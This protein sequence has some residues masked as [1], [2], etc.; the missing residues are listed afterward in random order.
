MIRALR[1]ARLLVVADGPRNDR[2]GEQDFVAKCRQ[3]VVPDWKCDFE[4]CYSETNLGCRDRIV[5][6]LNW[7]FARVEEAIILEDDCI[8]SVPFFSFAESMLAVYRDVPQVMS[9]SGTRVFPTTIEHGTSCLSKYSNCWGWATWRRAWQH[10]LTRLPAHFAETLKVTH[11]L[12]RERIYWKYI[13]NAADSGKLNTW[14]YLWMYSCWER[15]GLTLY[16]PHNLVANIGA[17]DEATHTTKLPYY[18][19]REVQAGIRVDSTHLPT[20]R[21]READRWIEDHMYS[22]SIWGRALWLADRIGLL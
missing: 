19:P 9:I 15:G 8:P 6:G 2:I 7:A 5:S 18:V 14:C 1:P 16:P 12:W 3:L 4:T 17:G 21:S 13:L 20:D 11:G 10:N 22:K